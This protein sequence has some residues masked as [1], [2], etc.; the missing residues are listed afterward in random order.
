MLMR[1]H[2]LVD[3]PEHDVQSAT[4]S[5]WVTNKRHM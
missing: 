4:V 5:M 3:V 1:C 2:T